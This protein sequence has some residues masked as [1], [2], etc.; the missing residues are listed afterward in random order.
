MIVM[1]AVALVA[2]FRVVDVCLVLRVVD[3][4]HAITIPHGG[5]SVAE[6]IALPGNADSD[7]RDWDTPAIWR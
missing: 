7:L 2:V 6:C 3:L 4:G 5:I 1:P